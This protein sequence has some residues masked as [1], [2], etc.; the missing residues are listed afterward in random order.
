MSLT[1]PK[2]PERLG[3]WDRGGPTRRLVIWG[4]GTGVPAGTVASAHVRAA[5]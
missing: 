5:R 4:G 1:R 3:V 2:R